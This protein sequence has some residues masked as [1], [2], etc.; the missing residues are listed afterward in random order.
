MSTTSMA[1][2]VITAWTTCKPCAHRATQARRH[3]KT[4]DSAIL[5]ELQAIRALLAELVEL[6]SAMV[7]ALASDPDGRESGE[8]PE[9]EPL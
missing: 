6:Q 8:R 3:G 5:A 2:L 7:E 9:G 4:V 1:T